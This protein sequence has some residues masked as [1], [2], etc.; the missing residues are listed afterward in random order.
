MFSPK[1]PY[2]VVMTIISTICSH[3]MRQKSAKVF[4]KGPEYKKWIEPHERYLLSSIK[5][6]TIQPVSY[7]RRLLTLSC[8]VGVTPLVPVHEAAIDVI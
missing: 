8:N 4:G 2:L 5:D 3:T 7:C 6:N 1:R